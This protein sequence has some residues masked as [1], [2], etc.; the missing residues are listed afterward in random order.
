MSKPNDAFAGGM[1]LGFV[2][3][4]LLWAGIAGYATNQDTARWYKEEAIKC[5]VGY[6]DATTGQFKYKVI[7]DEQISERTGESNGN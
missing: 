6:Y 3:G 7:R 1:F 4:G 2:L 5:G